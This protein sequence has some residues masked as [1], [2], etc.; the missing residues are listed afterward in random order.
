MKY[1]NALAELGAEFPFGEGRDMEVRELFNGS[2]RRILDIRLR[3][4]AV[5]KRHK[6]AEPITVQCVSGKGTFRA[7]PELEDSIQFR[8]GTLITLEPDVEHE[9]VAAPELHILVTRFKDA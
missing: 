2:R 1:I 9:A 8:S 7:G 6:A 3:N 4:S 5:L